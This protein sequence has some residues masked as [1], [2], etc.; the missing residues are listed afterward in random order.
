MAEVRYFL[1]AAYRNVLCP[2]ALT[3][4]ACSWVTASFVAIVL[5]PA[6]FIVAAALCVAVVLRHQQVARRAVRNATVRQLAFARIV[7]MDGRRRR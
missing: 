3:I 7:L 4:A 2:I 5:F 1:L 6:A